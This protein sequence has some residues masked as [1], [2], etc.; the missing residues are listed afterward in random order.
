[1]KSTK[2]RKICPT[3]SKKVI[4]VTKHG[5]GLMLDVLAGDAP[6]RPKIN[7]CCFCGKKLS[8]EELENNPREDPFASEIYDDDS[9]HLICD[10]CDYEHAMDI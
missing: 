5:M 3:C 10:E 9:L 4:D 8:K 7:C 6:V 2:T 1:M